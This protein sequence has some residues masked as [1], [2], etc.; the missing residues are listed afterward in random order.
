M[1][2]ELRLAKKQHKKLTPQ[3]ALWSKGGNLIFV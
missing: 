1:K 2:M 3:H